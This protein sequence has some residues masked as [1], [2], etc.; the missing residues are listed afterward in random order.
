MKFS[1][2]D[3]NEVAA[4][5]NN[6]FNPLKNVFEEAKKMTTAAGDNPLSEVMS[7]HFRKLENSFNNQVKPAFENMRVDLAQN[8]EN[9]E[10]FN[11][12]MNGVEMPNTSAVDNVEQKRHTQAFGAV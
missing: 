12:A 10:A 4:G 9:V 3:I 5:L 11:R 2:D 1:V 6:V 7:G 8:V